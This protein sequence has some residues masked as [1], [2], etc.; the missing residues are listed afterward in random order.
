MRIVSDN[1]RYSRAPLCWC[2]SLIGRLLWAGL[3]LIHIVPLVTVGSKLAVSSSLNL[4]LSFAA[5]LGIMT[6]A[7]LKAIDV[8]VLRFQLNSQKWCTLIVLGLFF[9][10]DVVA[11]QVPDIMVA[12]STMVVLVTIV[13]ASR[14]LQNL[15]VKRIISTGL[16]IRE[17]LYAR[18]EELA[19]TP[20]I[21]IY[22]LLSSPRPPPA[23]S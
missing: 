23:R 20:L 2:W 12:E 16:Q 11:K 1:T 22:A 15:A 9:H 5:I 18:M 3:F 8:R 6:I 4:F 17:T 21:P 13:C 10:G 19:P 14:R 7:L